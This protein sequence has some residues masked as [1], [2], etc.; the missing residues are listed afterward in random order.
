MVTLIICS[1]PKVIMRIRIHTG[2]LH[3]RHLKRKTILRLVFKSIFLTVVHEQ[4]MLLG[5]Y[6]Y[7][8]G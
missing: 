2:N 1:Y 3:I 5:I 6:I 7:N 8:T 4:S